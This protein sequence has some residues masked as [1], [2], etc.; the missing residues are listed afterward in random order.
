MIN[1][2]RFADKAAI[3]T[4]GFSGI[5]K[6]TVVRLAQEGAK[7]IATD[8]NEAA[9][10]NA[11]ED[12]K[13]MGLDVITLIADQSSE[14]DWKKVIEFAEEKFGAL[15]VLV[16]S[17][18]ISIRYELSE[19]VLSDWDKILAINLTGPMLGMRTA[20][21][22][23]RKTGGAI[24]NV[25]SIAGVT[26]H[27]TTA[28]S[29]SKWGLRGLSKSAA[30][31]F[32]DYGIRVNCVH[33]GIT[34]SGIIDPEGIAFKSNMTVCPQRRAGQAEELAAA[35]CFLASDDA[36]RITGID[37]NVDGGSAECG[38]YWAIWETTKRLAAETGGDM[39]S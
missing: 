20:L 5:G 23:M 36:S 34:V 26:G 27:P 16:H 25:G 12:F 21:P 31:E 28:Y 11:D 33:P 15:H 8:Y 9:Q 19:M 38:A 22:L 32:G 35:I 2:G 24:V 30:F 1:E 7:V 13:E 3:V 4:G 29:A 6:A 39:R 18:G 37:L 14:E 10:A 17:A